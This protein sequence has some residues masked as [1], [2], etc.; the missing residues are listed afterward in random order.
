MESC[1][2]FLKHQCLCFPT[3]KTFI[4]SVC[5]FCVNY[6]THPLTFHHIHPFSHAS[7]LIIKKKKKK[8]NNINVKISKNS[9]QR[10][11]FQM[12][13]PSAFKVEK[14]QR[15]NVL[16]S[17][18]VDVGENRGDRTSVRLKTMFSWGLKEQPCWLNIP[19]S[20]FSKDSSCGAKC[21]K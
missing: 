13:P 15:S 8:E 3:L 12:H 16:S 19:L 5:Y 21:G 10:S 4:K 17:D 7:D 1:V 2:S 6:W 11:P 20:C 18:S 9:C 14:L